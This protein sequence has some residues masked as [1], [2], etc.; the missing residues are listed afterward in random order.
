MAWRRDWKDARA[1]VTGASSGLGRAIAEA[2]VRRGARVVL[3]GRSEAR[4]GE[5]AAA[6]LRDGAAPHR[7]IV[8][9]P[10]Y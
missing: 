4:L 8:A 5:V 7:V 3:T 10:D 9:L 6:L 1:L 2:L